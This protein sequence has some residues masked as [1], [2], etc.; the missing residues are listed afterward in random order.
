MP[1]SFKPTLAKT[2]APN[3]CSDVYW[4]QAK[5]DGVR[6]ISTK[7]NGEIILYTRH[8]NVINGFSKIKR[9]LKKVLEDGDIVDGELYSEDIT[10]EEIC[11]SVKSG[12]NNL[13]YIVFDFI[14]KEVEDMGES[15]LYS[16]RFE[17]LKN[18]IAGLRHIAPVEHLEH[19]IE[20]DEAIQ[21]ATEY[22]V[23]KGWEGVILRTESHYKGG[24][25]NT[26]LKNKPFQDDEFKLIGYEETEKGRFIACLLTPSGE[27]FKA[28][29]AC[30]CARAY[31]NKMVTV[32]YQGTTS[33]G[34]PRFARVIIARDYE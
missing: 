7:E 32:R 16:D 5:V 24:R 1:L 9:E 3:T 29:C 31:I 15:L 30:A 19:T 20:G 10:F 14:E 2:Y 6:C 12:G 21:K 34:I 33:N 28:S 27:D 26:L 22:F 13:R 25:N 18:R 17:A 23:S 4:A 11:S 8:G